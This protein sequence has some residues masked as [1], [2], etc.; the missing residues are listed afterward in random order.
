MGITAYDA[1][2]ILQYV[3]GKISVFPVETGGVPDP[4]TKSLVSLRSICTGEVT[5]RADG[6]CSVPILIDEMDGVVAGELTLS[7][8]GHMG[9]A[10]VAASGLTSD[11]LLAGNVEEGQIRVSFAGAE[12][13]AG[14]GP[15]LEVV[16]D[17]EDSASLRS[18]RLERVSLNEGMIPTRVVEEMATPRAYRLGQNYPNPFNP[19]T[20]IRYDVA[21]AGPV[22]LAIYALTGQRVRTLVDAQ[23]SVGRYAVVWDG[24]DE[25]G[26]DVA[27]SVYLCRMETGGYRSVRKMLLI[28]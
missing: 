20:T 22:R 12:S 23:R 28:R 8:D 2:L 27:S 24:T 5:D 10:E 7:F 9:D 15:M 26:R 4:M 17:E 25:A 21:E 13:R 16:F 11:Y 19:E 1:S 3:V 14:S 18:L 6:R